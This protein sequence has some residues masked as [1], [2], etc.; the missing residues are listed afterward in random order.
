MKSNY[1]LSEYERAVV[2]SMRAGAS[3]SVNFFDRVDSH[4]CEVALD[5]FTY[6]GLPVHADVLKN[7]TQML[8]GYTQIEDVSRDGQHRVKL[9]FLNYAAMTKKPAAVAPATDE[10]ENSTK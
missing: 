9:G 6:L 1:V 2:E 4:D 3:I 10:V 7:K 8:A 5:S